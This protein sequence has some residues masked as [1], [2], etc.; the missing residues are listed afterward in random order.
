MKKI[1]LMGILIVSLAI[2]AG[3]A[4][5]QYRENFT[6]DQKAL[7]ELQGR[8][9]WCEAEGKSDRIAWLMDRENIDMGL[10]MRRHYYLTDQW[11]QSQLKYM[12]KGISLQETETTCIPCDELMGMSLL[13]YRFYGK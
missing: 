8:Q 6:E 3:C 12:W 13:D 9:I 1:L 4:N 11:R 10:Q 2:L 5:R 7:A